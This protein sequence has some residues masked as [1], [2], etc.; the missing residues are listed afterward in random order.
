MRPNPQ[1]LSGCHRQTRASPPIKSL[2]PSQTARNKCTMCHC[3]VI[4]SNLDYHVADTLL[5][6]TTIQLTVRNISDFVAI[7]IISLFFYQKNGATSV[8][9]VYRLPHIAPAQFLSFFDDTI[10]YRSPIND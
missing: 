7:A 5:V 8:L 2:N 10:S 3:E 4:R 9:F 6:M 1:F